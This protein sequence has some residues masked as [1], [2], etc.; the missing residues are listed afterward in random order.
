MKKYYKSLFLLLTL[1]I[2]SS[3]A[4]A[5]KL[6]YPYV[7]A[8]SEGLFSKVAEIFDLFLPFDADITPYAKTGPK[9]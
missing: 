2:I 5:D 6:V 4:A 7:F 1:F 8:P 3:L 9:S